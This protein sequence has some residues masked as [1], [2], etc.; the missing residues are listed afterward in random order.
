MIAVVALHDA[1][2]LAGFER[3]HG[4][5][6]RLDHLALTEDIAVGIALQPAVLAVGLHQL[7][8]LRL[9]LRRV[10]DRLELREQL[11]G[12]RALLG[13]LVVRE[14][15]AGG[16]VL[17]Q[18][19]DVLGAHQAVVGGVLGQLALGGGVL[20]A[21]GAQTG[22]HVAVHHADLAQLEH[23]VVGQAHGLQIIL[24]GLLAAELLL[25]LGA[26]L[27]VVGLVL[28]G[29]LIPGRR[30]LR[31][32]DAVDDGG[33]LGLA[34]DVLVHG[35]PAVPVDAG[36]PIDRAAHRTVVRG[37]V[38]RVLGHPEEIVARGDVVPVHLEE[39]RRAGVA[40]DLLHRVVA[41]PAA[42]QHARQ[43][44]RA[45]RDRQAPAHDSF[46]FVVLL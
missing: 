16:H 2:D 11:L 22:L 20:A 30:G 13:L 36:R 14:D 44:H 40:H 38:V 12:L 31:R 18:Q 27:V 41:A 46:H 32:H 4:V 7:V 9:Q 1:G 23:Q 3:L 34:L 45:E 35:G 6:E 25:R 8:E 26:L 33:V 10:A 24:I 19:Q 15:L 21:V 42:G 5:L 17:R 28:G 37:D 43:Q 29:E 39:D